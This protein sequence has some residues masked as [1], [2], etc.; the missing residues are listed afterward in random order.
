LEWLLETSNGWETWNGRQ[1]ALGR[2][3]P[4]GLASGPVEQQG[5]FQPITAAYIE[6]RPRILVAAIPFREDFAPPKFIRAISL[7]SFFF[8]PATVLRNP[9]TVFLT[10][11]QFFV[12]RPV[13]QP[14]IIWKNGS[15]DAEESFLSQS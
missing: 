6:T 7:F 5:D 15:K 1:W 9:A 3:G 4:R 14:K 8:N 11:L 10:R 13:L 12:T 2:P